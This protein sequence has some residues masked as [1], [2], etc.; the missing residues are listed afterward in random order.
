[1]KAAMAIAG[2]LMR[3]WRF[4]KNTVS[5]KKNLETEIYCRINF[6]VV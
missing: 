4:L 5:G 2:T 1:M 6:G 3:R